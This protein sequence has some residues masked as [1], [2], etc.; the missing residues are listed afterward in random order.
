MDKK[1]L[2]HCIV[3][4]KA[5]EQQKATNSHKRQDHKRENLFVVQPKPWFTSRKE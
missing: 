1:R 5:N 3:M 2:N 4:N